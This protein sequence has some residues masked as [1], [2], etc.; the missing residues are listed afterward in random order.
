MPLIALLSE[1][2]ALGPDE[3]R[4]IIGYSE[5]LIIG[6]QGGRGSFNEEAALTHL[7][8]IITADYE[9]RYLYTTPNVFEAL[10]KGEI[11]RGQFA[12]FNIWADSMRKAYTQ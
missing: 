12:I 2:S 7:P 11:D 4:E 10:D 8:Q 3:A 1:S 9:L 6:I 5:M